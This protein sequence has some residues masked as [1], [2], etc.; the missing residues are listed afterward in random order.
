MYL[1]II[2]KKIPQDK[3]CIRKR[4]DY[5]S[6]I[7]IEEKNILLDEIYLKALILLN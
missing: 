5:K 2:K 7:I 6:K 4:N 3:R 1:K